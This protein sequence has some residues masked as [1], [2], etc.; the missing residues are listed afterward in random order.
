MH[1]MA[2]DSEGQERKQEATSVRAHATILAL[3]KRRQEDHREQVQSSLGYKAHS[4]QG[5]IA[6]SAAKQKTKKLGYS[7][8]H[9]IA[10]QIRSSRPSSDTK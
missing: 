10:S 8:A 4:S 9:L 3:E 5:S 6:R 7:G 2:S 1:L